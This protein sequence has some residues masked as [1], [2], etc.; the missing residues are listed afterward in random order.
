MEAIGTLAGG[1]AHDFN[2]LM[3]GMLGNVSIMML[4]TEVNSPHY[5]KLKK[6]EQLIQSG[7]QLTSQLLG[8]ARKGTFALKIV[9]LNKI[10]KDSVEIFGRT[11]KDIAIEMDLSS[12]AGPVEI[13]RSQVEQVLFNLFINAADAMPDGGDIR[14]DT[15]IVNRSEIGKKPYKW[16]PAAMSCFRSRT[17]ATVW[18]LK[19]K[20]A[21]LILFFYHQG[22]G[23]GHGPGTGIRVWHH[24]I[25]RRLHRRGVG[26]RSGSNLAFICR[27]RKEVSPKESKATRPSSSARER[28]WSWMTK[29]WSSRSVRR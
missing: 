12:A 28:Y 5:E 3:M 15:S 8:Y 4:D 17:R 10:V 1:L 20:S 7:S 11:R 18:T 2:N 23:T 19:R 13:D 22:D 6:V 16:N 29:I 26:N 24:E 9:D 25:A 14:L 21:F 27:S